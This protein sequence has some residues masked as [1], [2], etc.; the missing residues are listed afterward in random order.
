MSCASESDGQAPTAPPGR[1]GA[2]SRRR[3]WFAGGGVLGLAVIMATVLWW[4]GDGTASRAYALA[5]ESVLPARVRAAPPAVRRAYRFAI[6]NREILSQ[7]PCYCGCGAVHQNNY[8]CYIK[9]ANPDG[10]F[11]FDDMSLG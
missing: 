1:G 4:L 10:T 11:V 9:A 8:Q 7:I 6:A 2:A 3:L 5:P